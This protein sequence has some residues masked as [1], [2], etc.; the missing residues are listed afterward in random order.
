VSIDEVGV[1]KLMA[2]YGVVVDISMLETLCEV[3]YSN[4]TEARNACKSLRIAGF[5]VALG[6]D[7]PEATLSGKDGSGRL[8]D[9]K[10]REIELDN[11]DSTSDGISIASRDADTNESVVHRNSFFSHFL[12]YPK[13]VCCGCPF[14]YFCILLFIAL[15]IF[16]I[17]VCVLVTDLRLNVLQV[18]QSF[19]SFLRAGDGWRLAS[20]ACEYDWV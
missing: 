16:P 10:S 5:T 19:W 14:L 6:C 17:G 1:K 3:Q 2:Q 9:R 12:K 11:L 20:T 18:S 8:L 7:V 15:V 13:R 4:S